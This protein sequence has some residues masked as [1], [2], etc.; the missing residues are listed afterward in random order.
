RA[1]SARRQGA[2]SWG[3]SLSTGSD[4]PAHRLPDRAPAHG[5]AAPRALPF[6]TG[7][8]VAGGRS[9]LDGAGLPHI[10][11]DVG[12]AARGAPAAPEHRAVRATLVTAVL[13]A[14]VCGVAAA[15]LYLAWP[16]RLTAEEWVLHRRAVSAPPVPRVRVSPSRRALLTPLDLAGH[17]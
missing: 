10:A 15:G 8:G 7:P 1:A 2:E 16:R 5:P 6:G 13:L 4:H 3:R 14:A 12:A 9:P 11:A 17:F